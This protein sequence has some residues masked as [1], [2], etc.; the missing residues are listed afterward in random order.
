MDSWPAFRFPNLCLWSRGGIRH[1]LDNFKRRVR[2]SNVPIIPETDANSIAF[3]HWILI[4]LA[5]LV[6]SLMDILERF[7][8]TMTP[9]RAVTSAAITAA[10]WFV[11]IF[12]GL[13]P[14]FVDFYFAVLAAPGLAINLAYFAL[15]SFAFARQKK[16]GDKTQGDVAAAAGDIEL[17]TRAAA[18]T[19]SR[20]SERVEQKAVNVETQAWTPLK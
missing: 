1:S 13:L 15:A 17:D 12:L 16:L 2:C 10:L 18:S 20:S 4:P 11:Y 7:Q 6:I 5:T 8:R 14:N 9:I 3:A 19:R